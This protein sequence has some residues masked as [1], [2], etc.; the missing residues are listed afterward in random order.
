MEREGEKVVPR[1]SPHPHHVA[2]YQDGPS[3]WRPQ[4]AEGQ[5]VTRQGVCPDLQDLGELPAVLEFQGGLA[6]ALQAAPDLFCLLL[7]GGLEVEAAQ[8]GLV[9][10]N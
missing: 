7:Q 5:V 1:S 10:G 8:A 9:F 3:G 6:Q 4:G 2:S